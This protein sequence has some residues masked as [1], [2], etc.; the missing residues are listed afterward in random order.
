MLRN[1]PIRRKLMTVNLLISGVVLLLTCTAFITYEVVTL[2][3]GMVQGYLTRANIIAANSTAS[4]AFQNENDAEEVLTA[5]KTDPRIIRACIYDNQGNVF[6]KYPVNSPNA[7]EPSQLSVF[8][9]VVQ[10]DRTLGT[11]CLQS[12]LTALTD[13]Y[14]AYGWLAAFIIS[15]SVIIAY[16]LSSLLQKQ[17]SRPILTLAE[18]A[19]AIS[20]N[21]DFSVRATKIGRDELGLLTDAFNQL[22]VSIESRDKAL[23]EEITERIRAE[24]KA[25]RE[26]DRFKLIFDCVPVGIA[27]AVRQP[28]GKINRIINDAHL[29]ICGLTR[30]QDQLPDIYTRLRHPDDSAR[31]DEF[32]RQIAAG[33]INE[34]S[35]EKRYIRLDGGVVWVTFSYQRHQRPDGSLEEVTT[36]VDITERKNAESRAQAQL[37]RLELLNR[38]TRATSERQDLQSIFQV[39][40]RTLEDHLPVD[41]CCICL[42]D[43]AANT[44]KVVHVGVKSEATAMALAMSE[45][46]VIPIDANGLSQCVRGRLVYEPD[47]TQIQFPFPQR[48]ARGGLRALV[49]A[50]LLVES[51]VFGV[52]ISARRAPGSFSSGDCEFL[53]QLSEHVALAAHQ[54][55]LNDALRQAYE[56]LRQTQQAVMQQERL[57][58]LGQM[59]SGIAHDINNAISPV[60]LYTESLLDKEPNLSPRARDYLTTIQHAIEDV[61]QTVARMREFYRQRETQLA[62]KPVKLNPLIQQVIELSRAR[63]SDMPQQRGVFIKMETSLAP[64]LPAVLGVESEIRE[65]LVN[66][67]F[68]AVDAMP[69]GGTLTLRTGISGD[70]PGFA[71][72]EVIDTGVGMNEDTRRRCLEPFFTTKGERGT[73]LGL[74]MVYGIARRHNAEIEIDSAPGRGTTM[75]LVFP[76]PAT[77]TA[78]GEKVVSV[79]VMPPRLRILVVDDDPLL[80]KSLR[81]TLEADGHVIVTANTGQDGI[82]TFR[83]ASEGEEPFAV[84][85]TD[86]GMPYVDGR[87]VAAAVKNISPA[88]PVILLT[89]WGQRL[90]AEGDIPPHVDR[91]LNKPPKLRELREALV[92]CLQS[93]S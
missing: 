65:A 74:A 32:S 79:S 31:Q 37:A 18:T 28:D 29:R 3:K 42:Y 83:R 10:G 20:R 13:R 86:L 38:I 89:G 16:L 87:Q 27:F 14:S 26:E 61:A 93:K 85:I 7:A 80:I 60:A 50:P 64:E 52:L 24:E 59:A 47:I 66:L 45:Q 78:S 72:V 49:A 8:C 76:I 81:D 23:R 12:D 21:H 88:T 43:Q 6:A 2:R 82:D 22:L 53:R 68:N 15:G 62:M 5:L 51:K 75:R 67:L 69:E 91:V 56:D 9:P 57:K 90:V 44:L 54:A 70:A 33:K 55:Q 40:I 71:R 39:V 35:M 19:G 46:A 92:Q 58:A 34:F 25:A 1:L 30:E 77:E 84:V 11:V 73:G 63:W 48:L 17:I 36:V 4:L 41:F